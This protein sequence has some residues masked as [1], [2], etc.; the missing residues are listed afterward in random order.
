MLGPEGLN[1]PRSD[2]REDAPGA[3][4]GGPGGF[5]LIEMMVA[6][7]IGMIGIAATVWIVFQSYR[8]MDETTRVTRLQQDIDLAAYTMKGFIEEAKIF[9]V[10]DSGSRLVVQGNPDGW[11]RAFYRNGA[12]LIME[13]LP[14]STPALRTV[15][16]TAQALSFTTN[17]QL[18]VITVNLAVARDGL[19]YGTSF[20]VKL[21][22]R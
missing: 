9:A 13:Y 5:T 20:A 12:D 6:V 4:A 10:T 18:G 22:N 14:P 15:I 1:R 3:R 7:L 2:T 11:K 8:S 19:G 21:K 16:T 17:P